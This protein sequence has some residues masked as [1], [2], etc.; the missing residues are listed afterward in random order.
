MKKVYLYS[1]AFVAGYSIMALELLGFRIFAP[2]FGNT[3]FV[4]G[5]LIGTIMLALSAG[6]FAGG[7]ISEKKPDQKTLNFL[8]LTACGYLI[9]VNVFYPEIL[10][11]CTFAGAS[12]G[13][14]LATMIMF[15]I[16]MI[17]LSSLS[18]FLIKIKALNEKVGISAG[19]IYAVSTMGSLLGTFLTT[20]VLIP[21]LGSFKT[22]LITNSVIFLLLAW[23]LARFKL[24]YLILIPVLIPMFM[25]NPQDY[26]KKSFKHL[27]KWYRGVGLVYISESPYNMVFISKYRN[28]YTLHL[29]GKG[30][31]SFYNSEKPDYSLK[32]SSYREIFGLLARITKPRNILILGMGGG[33]SLTRY[34]GINDS[35]KIDAVEIDPKVIQASELFFGIRESENVKF[36]LADARP[37]VSKVNKKYDFIEIDTYNGD[38]QIPFY[39][40]TEEFF[41][42]VNNKLSDSG[43]FVM[44]VVS[45][46]TNRKNDWVADPIANTMTR[47]FKKV[48][49]IKWKGSRIIFGLKKD[50]SL[51]YFREKLGNMAV[52]NPVYE[53]L[54]KII[55]QRIMALGHNPAK[56]IL[57]DD[58][59]PIEFLTRKLIKDRAKD[60][61]VL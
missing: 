28:I 50:V 6:Y 25:I 58:H 61:L 4:W 26:L 33:T 40:A 47:V 31:Q 15:C 3:I 7:Y 14:L 17:I 22:F 1:V 13:A 18:P 39:L 52:K 21:R 56:L 32:K 29:N 44:N 43:I 9:P 27:A 53:D 11:F 16:P 12:G 5:S 48:F 45:Q 10:G 36:H 19:K 30:R 24:K 20:F 49:S 23:S 59:C 60:P 41:A 55:L 42:L 46:K 54:I 37:F 35:L 2:Y 8:L 38:F 51:N 57:T 34:L